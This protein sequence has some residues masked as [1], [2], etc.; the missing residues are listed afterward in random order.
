MRIGTVITTQHGTFP[1]CGWNFAICI[2]TE[3]TWSPLIKSAANQLV[4]YLSAH[5]GLPPI[6]LSFPSSAQV[7]LGSDQKCCADSPLP[8]RFWLFR[9]NCLC[10]RDLACGVDCQHIANKPNA[11]PPRTQCGQHVLSSEQANG[12]CEGQSGCPCNIQ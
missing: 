2:K 3:Q 11:A 8:L 4:F 12:Q 9:Y 5:F 10:C 7:K 1:R 6:G